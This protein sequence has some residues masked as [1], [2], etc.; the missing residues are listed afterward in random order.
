MTTLLIKN[1]DGSFWISEDFYFSEIA[2]YENKIDEYKKIIKRLKE[3]NY[4][5]EEENIKLKND[6]VNKLKKLGG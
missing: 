6:I 2:K 1:K 5:L 3:E 4:N